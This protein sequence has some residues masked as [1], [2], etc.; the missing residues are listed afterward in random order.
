V[1]V[2]VVSTP[3][4]LMG[5]FHH[6]AKPRMRAWPAAW[7]EFPDHQPPGAAYDF[8]DYGL[9]TGPVVSTGRNE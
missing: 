9:F 1:E 8:I 7:A 6:P 2:E 3:R 5:P 4:N